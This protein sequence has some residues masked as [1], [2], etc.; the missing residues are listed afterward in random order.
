MINPISQF[1][2]N[3]EGIAK[4][5]NRDIL[6]TRCHRQLVTLPGLKCHIILHFY[7][8]KFSKLYAELNNRPNYNFMKLRA[9]VADY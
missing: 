5:H 8:I 1:L 6:V 7:N 3:R 2:E 4:H 9:D